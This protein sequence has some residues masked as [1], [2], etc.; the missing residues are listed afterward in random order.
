MILLA[1]TKALMIV[2]TRKQSYEQVRTLGY[3]AGKIFGYFKCRVRTVVLCQPSL[4]VSLLMYNILPPSKLSGE[5][6]VS[7]KREQKFTSR[8]KCTWY[9]RHTVEENESIF[10]DDGDSTTSKSR[11]DLTPKTFYLSEDL[12]KC[13]G[14][15]DYQVRKHS[16]GK[17]HQ[18]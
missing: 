10:R 5:G 1:S 11:K 14:V 4:S 15:S 8:W 9:P 13:V 3:V 17:Y 2:M 12:S 7:V 16:P 6:H 18:Q